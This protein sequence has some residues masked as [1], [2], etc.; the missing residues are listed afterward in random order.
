MA[1]KIVKS[2][3]A[4]WPVIFPGVTEEGAVVEN[5]FRMRFKLLDEDE[6]EQLEREL[7]ELVDRD[8]AADMKRTELAAD[9]TLRI[10]EDW[11]GVTMEGDN[12]AEISLPFGRDNI[13][14]MVRIPNVF[15]GIG[16]AYRSCR[17]GEPEKR[18][19]N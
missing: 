12:G 19:G 10:A 2:P 11:Q 13:L 16:T 1:Y 14:T 6:H 9:F 8:D 17:A 7:R 4:W 5:E 3:R 15:K 18:R